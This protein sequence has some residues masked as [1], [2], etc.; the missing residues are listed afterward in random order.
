MEDSMKELCCLVNGVYRCGACKIP[1]CSEHLSD[2]YRIAK[3]PSGP[4]C[5]N[6]GH[7]NIWVNLIDRA[8]G[9]RQQAKIDERLG[10]KNGT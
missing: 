7:E 4:S 6:C 10:R 9:A 8:M 1:Y 2:R 5:P 3:R